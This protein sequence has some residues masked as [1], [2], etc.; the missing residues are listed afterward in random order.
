MADDTVSVLDSEGKIP[1]EQISDKT[2]I[3]GTAIKSKGVDSGKVLTADGA[4]GVSWED[5]GGGVTDHDNLTNVTADQHHDKSHAISH[6]K[7]GDDEINVDDLSGELAQPQKQKAS[8]FS[9]GASNT[10]P[11][12]FNTGTTYAVRRRWIFRGTNVMGIPTAIKAIMRV[13][14]A[15]SGEFRIYDLTNAQTICE[16]TTTSGTFVIVNSGT[17]SNL[18]TGEA[19]FEIQLKCTSPGNPSG[20]VEVTGMVIQW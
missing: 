12:I 17:I 16:C 1:V 20:Y 5:A 9:Y 11:T 2:P 14:N 4:D 10:D 8:D 18:P 7:D 13:V 15:T 19:I 3:E 6:E